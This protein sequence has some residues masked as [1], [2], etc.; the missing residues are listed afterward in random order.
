MTTVTHLTTALLYCQS[1]L[2]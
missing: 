1:S 2:G